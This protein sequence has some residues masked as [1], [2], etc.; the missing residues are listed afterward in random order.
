MELARRRGLAM[1]E[2]SCETMFAE[3]EGQPAGSFDDVACFS[4]YV[5]HFFKRTPEIEIMCVQDQGGPA[6]LSGS[7]PP[8]AWSQ[9]HEP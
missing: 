8:D 4:T 3:Y 5:A 9:T 2:E 6:A 1:V 7:Q